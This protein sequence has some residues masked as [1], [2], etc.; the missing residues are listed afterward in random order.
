[1]RPLED[2]IPEV[3]RYMPSE[4]SDKIKEALVDTAI[5]ICKKT[6]CF[7]EPLYINAIQNV[8]EYP[9]PEGINVLDVIPEGRT[10]ITR[11]GD[12]VF[13]DNVWGCRNVVAWLVTGPTRTACELPDMLYDKWLRVIVDGTVSSLLLFDMNVNSVNMS[14]VFARRYSAGIGEIIVDIVNKKS[15]GQL[16]VR[17]KK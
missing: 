9:L 14:T 2:F 5:D 6:R 3:L 10:K 12:S 13:I 8:K 11:S 7:V 17:T 4:D 1:M 15:N 16:E